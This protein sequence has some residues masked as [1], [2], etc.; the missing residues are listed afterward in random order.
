ME[1]P[2]G[3]ECPLMSGPSTQPRSCRP[4]KRCRGE[5]SPQLLVFVT[6]SRRPFYVQTALLCTQEGV[7]GDREEAG[8]VTRLEG[9][10]NKQDLIRA[11][12]LDESSLSKPSDIREDTL[13]REAVHFVL[14]V[15][16][17]WLLIVFRKHVWQGQTMCR[18]LVTGFG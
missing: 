3:S 10:G 14:T 7:D 18:S 11:K 2:V 13:F 15:D 8:L 12:S 4:G 5:A 6:Q 17:G 16:N 9:V 1:R